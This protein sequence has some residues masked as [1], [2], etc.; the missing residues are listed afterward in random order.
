MLIRFLLYGV[1]LGYLALDLF[2]MKGP[3]WQRVEKARTDQVA[4]LNE[5]KADGLVA[6]VFSQ[7]IVIGQVDRRVRERFFLGGIDLQAVSAEQLLLHRIIAVNDLVDEALLRR[8]ADTNSE[9]VEVTEADIDEEMLRVR[10]S[11]GGEEGLADYLQSQ[12]YAGEKELRYRLAARL[13]QVRHIDRIIA[14]SLEISDEAIAAF[15]EGNRSE[16]VLPRQLRVRQIFIETLNRG[17]AAGARLAD[18]LLAQVQGGANFPQLAA[19][20]SDDPRSKKVGGELGWLAD[21]G[22]MA[23]DFI[24]PVMGLRAG[25]VQI[26]KSRIGYHLVE[27]MEEKPGREL[28]LTEV[29]DQ[30]ELA[31]QN[32][33][34]VQA[35]EAYRKR[36]R[37][38][39][40]RHWVIYRDVIEGAGALGL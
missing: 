28:A 2:V 9:K 13:Q 19:E 4:A 23:E 32:E 34:R 38:Q 3:V 29:R 37:R 15:Y 8:K 6:Q 7:S 40:E 12:R 16:Y 31:L 35:I 26:V 39:H 30:I 5:K 14:P 22:R 10:E 18:E 36:L 27:V 1:V 25:D 24:A 33:A 17:D 20:V 21:D 11:L